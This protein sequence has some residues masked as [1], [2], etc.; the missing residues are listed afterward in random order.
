MVVMLAVF[1][2]IMI[3]LKIM[4]TAVTGLMM[5]AISDDGDDQ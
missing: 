3:P 5:M 1:K 4:S 2:M